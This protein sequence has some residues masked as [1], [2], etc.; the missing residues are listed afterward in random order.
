MT[1]GVVIFLNVPRLGEIFALQVPVNPVSKDEQIDTRR[2]K[3]DFGS[4]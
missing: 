3:R 4:A 2:W 1:I